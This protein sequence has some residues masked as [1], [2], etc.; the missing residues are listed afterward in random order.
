MTLLRRRQANFLMALRVDGSP[1]L[2]EAKHNYRE[3]ALAAGIP[4]FDELTNTA[5]ALA[6]MR[7]L[8][9]RMAERHSAAE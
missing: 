6:A 5:Q 1:D 8:K 3:R 4:V 9:E 7:Q 2:D